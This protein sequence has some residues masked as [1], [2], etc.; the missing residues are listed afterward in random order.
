MQNIVKKSTPGVINFKGKSPVGRDQKLENRV[1]STVGWSRVLAQGFW[2]VLAAK[3]PLKIHLNISSLGFTLGIF[4]EHLESPV[5]FPYKWPVCPFPHDTLIILTLHL[6]S[7]LNFT[8]SINRFFKK[9]SGT[10]FPTG[11]VEFSPGECSPALLVC[12][13]LEQVSSSPG[14]GDL[15]SG[16]GA[17]LHG[18]FGEVLSHP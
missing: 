1:S 8:I 12:S 5:S 11:G 9:P 17:E 13:Y 15:G 6:L 14:A 7:F 16:G 10:T 2:T 3:W 18:D 4:F